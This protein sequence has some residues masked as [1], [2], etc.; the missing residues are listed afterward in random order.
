MLAT[1][2]V[3]FVLCACACHPCG[4]RRGARALRAAT[5][6]AHQEEFEEL[7]LHFVFIRGEIPRARS[8]PD[9]PMARRAQ[10]GCF[11][12]TPVESE[13]FWIA[14]TETTVDAWRMFDPQYELPELLGGTGHEGRLPVVG[15]N[16]ERIERYLEW[17]TS[18]SEVYAYRLPTEVEWEHAAR[19]GDPG[20]APWG[21][22]PALAVRYANFQDAALARVWPNNRAV[23]QSDGYA[24]LAPVASFLPN[25]FG[26]FDTLGN[27]YE[28]CLSSHSPSSSGPASPGVATSPHRTGG[29]SMVYRGGGWYSSLD[30]V[31]YAERQVYLTFRVESEVGFRVVATRKLSRGPGRP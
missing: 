18:R 28:L 21:D 5:V 15:V 11:R 1:L 8:T 27:A 29:R 14:R 19:A 22:Q 20:D 2:G 31:S 7:G 26:L 12:Y 4:A 3:A 25:P 30:E 6:V 9:E 23:A 10:G 16:V 17:R 13:G 24:Y